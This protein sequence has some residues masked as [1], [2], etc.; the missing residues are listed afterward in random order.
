MV[1]NSAAP[2]SKNGAFGTICLAGAYHS[3]ILYIVILVSSSVL[4]FSIRLAYRTTKKRPRV[5]AVNE[6]G[7][8]EGDPAV[9]SRQRD[10]TCGLQ[11]QAAS[12]RNTR[13]LAFSE[14]LHVGHHLLEVRYHLLNA[15]LAL[16]LGFMQTLGVHQNRAVALQHPAYYKL[17]NEHFRSLLASKV[18]MKTRSNLL[19]KT[20]LIIQYRD[21]KNAA[22][23]KKR[24][25]EATLSDGDAQM[26]HAASDIK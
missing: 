23:S 4:N 17:R 7:P 1:M 12:N 21:A 20:G 8:P 3:E 10:I 9:C 25:P 22:P 2:M 5:S 16:L 13:F 24:R 15:R 11:Y 14:H 19:C 26:L 6:K 18:K